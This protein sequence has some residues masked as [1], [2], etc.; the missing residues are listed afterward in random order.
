MEVKQVTR[1]LQPLS[2]VRS[3]ARSALFPFFSVGEMVGKRAPETGGTL[4]LS[5]PF[6]LLHS[7]DTA[8]QS[9]AERRQEREAA[10]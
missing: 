2:I 7:K 10:Q 1:L 6:F 5:N 3:P 8:Q 4:T 9:Q